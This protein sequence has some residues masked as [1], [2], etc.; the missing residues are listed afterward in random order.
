MLLILAE[1]LAK[2]HSGFDVFRY[3]TLR[4]I[5]GV[6]TAL[7][8]VQLLFGINYI[9]SKIVVSELTPLL[10]PPPFP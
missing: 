1:W 3:L 10:T 4:T 7:F 2:Y 8:I 6:L 5:L 9:V